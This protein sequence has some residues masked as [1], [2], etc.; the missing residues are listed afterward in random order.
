MNT[1]L[2]R[3]WD[4][5]SNRSRAAFLSICSRWL[6]FFVLAAFLAQG[7]DDDKLKDPALPGHHAVA[8]SEYKPDPA[9]PGDPLGTDVSSYFNSPDFRVTYN[10]N[11]VPLHGI[12]R[13]PG[14]HGPFP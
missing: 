5:N 7:C 12:V 1:L 4:W 3:R 2:E 11:H 8:S 6:A 13:Y 14:G 10:M 9:N